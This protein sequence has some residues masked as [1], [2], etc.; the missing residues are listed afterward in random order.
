LLG[1]T[2]ELAFA[3]ANADSQGERCGKHTEITITTRISISVKP[4]TAH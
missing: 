2:L 3:A 1:L 4:A